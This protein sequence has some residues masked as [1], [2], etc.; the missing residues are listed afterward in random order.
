MSLLNL[1]K[2]LW[3]EVGNFNKMKQ[4]KFHENFAMFTKIANISAKFVF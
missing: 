1:T 3:K 2:F 4:A